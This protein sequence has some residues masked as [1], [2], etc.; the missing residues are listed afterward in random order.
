MKV[1]FRKR[2]KVAGLICFTFFKDIVALHLFVKKE[3][4]HWG[5]RESWY[6]GPIYEFG[7]GPFLLWCY[8][9]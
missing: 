8:Y 6:N 4:R 5:Y 1:Y 2:D 9:E 3:C 7:L